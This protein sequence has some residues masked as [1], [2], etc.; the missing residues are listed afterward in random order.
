MTE[1]DTRPTQ[2]IGIGT[3][4][5]SLR[6]N[7]NFQ[8]LWTSNLFFFGGV[9]TQTL[10]LGW[11][12]FEMTGSEFLV[13]LFTAVRLAPLLLG[14]IA[15]ALTDRFDKVRLLLVACGWATTAIAVVSFLASFGML[16][17]WV[18]VAGGLAIGLAQSPSQTAR[19][20]L[21][22]ELVGTA[23]LSNANAL[24]S[25]AMNMTQV[26]GP[27]IGGA[28]IAGLGA[29]AALWVSTAW[30]AIS[31][32]LLLLP[33]RSIPHVAHA[34]PESV[35]RMLVS[36]FRLIGGN[37]LAVCVLMVTVVANTFLWPVYQ[38]FMP[39]FA[40]QRF[41]L[42]ADGL[43]VMLSCSGIGGLIGSVV[44]AS[45]GDFRNKGALFVFG[46][47]VWGALWAVFAMLTSPPAGFL[48]LAI[49]G[50]ASAAFGV[51]QTTLLLIVT[52]KPLHGRVLGLQELA[53]GMIPIGS[54]LLG[55]LAQTFGV[56]VV[57]FWAAVLLVLSV[58]IVAV[59]TPSVLRI[60]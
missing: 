8:L 34:E 35:L 58:G 27:A 28:M 36:G 2:R 50:F 10:V 56:A 43:G 39:V 20:S 41:G 12:A 5:S 18:L 49:A 59:R 7:R 38:S 45:L 48:V 6:G 4:V 17:Y 53:I 57:T 42:D 14:P 3:A 32:A 60:R 54:L 33:L 21:A 31:F 24:N 30:Y 29:P 47:M 16:S 23:N 11:M 25:L 40:D 52:A 46:T 37:R 22:L 9:W 55:V 15:G 26:V 51:L 44:I 13:A 1:A 19:A